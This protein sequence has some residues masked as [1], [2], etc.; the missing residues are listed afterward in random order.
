MGEQ[1]GVKETKDVV[2]LIAK[3]VMAG[4]AIAADKKVDW[5]DLSHFMSVAPSLIGALD[6][7]QHVP[8]E[9]SNL[10]MEE[11]EE[12]LDH[13]KSELVI[14]DDAKAKEVLEGAVEMVKGGSRIVLALVK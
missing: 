8:N 2:V 14:D 7:I 4:R 5:N 3:S 11:V 6:G 9:V 12:I 13:L 10:S 1:Y